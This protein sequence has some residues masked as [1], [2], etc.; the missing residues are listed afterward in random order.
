MTFI[1]SVFV[2]N[3]YLFFVLNQGQF[4]I[5]SKLK[6]INF[7]SNYSNFVDRL[8]FKLKQ[9]ICDNQVSGTSA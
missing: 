7:E 6:S 4:C 2:T 5:L 8:F 9:S 1:M 3:I